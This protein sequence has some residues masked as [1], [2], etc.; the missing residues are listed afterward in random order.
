MVTD[1]LDGAY[2]AQL[3]VIEGGTSVGK[4]TLAKSLTERLSGYGIPC[5]YVK[6]VPSD[7]NR[8]WLCEVC[9]G[10]GR[11]EENVL[12]LDDMVNV[13]N[14][15]RD[16]VK[17]GVTVVMDK[18]V[19]SKLSYSRS[20]LPGEEYEKLIERLDS[21][22]LIEPDHM[23]LLT[24]ALET[25]YDR[26]KEKEDLSPVDLKTIHD[27]TLEGYLHEE[28]QRYN[29]IVVDSGAYAADELCSYCLRY[30]LRE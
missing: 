11:F 24:A 21:S 1:H 12:F 14:K 5:E 2:Q 19:P 28:A 8:E 7:D 23:F 3:I 25:R 27:E 6:A 20:D 29:P 13:A 10:L 18:Y 16:L 26:M 22:D 30:I 9:V 15:A 17:E 4:T